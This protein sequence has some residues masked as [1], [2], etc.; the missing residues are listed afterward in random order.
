MSNKHHNNRPPM[1]LTPR[2]LTPPPVAAAPVVEPPGPASE[3][4]SDTNHGNES[5]SGN[6]S[7]SGQDSFGNN[8]ESASPYGYGGHVE[9]SNLAA[10]IA[11][12]SGAESDDSLYELLK[13]ED[14]APVEPDYVKFARIHGH[15]GN[16]NTNA[17]MVFC[18][19]FPGMTRYVRQAPTEDY[20]TAED[21]AALKAA[22]AAAE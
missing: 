7:Q 16:D 17:W 22:I 3:A 14:E 6:E 8:T 10:T 15:I 5:T 19:N 2:G 11:G 9:Y 4:G 13:V 21:R 20:F 1:T 12:Y 18:I